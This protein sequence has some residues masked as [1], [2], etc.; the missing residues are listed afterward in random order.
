MNKQ[1]LGWLFF[2]ALIS[3]GI[4][5]SESMLIDVYKCSHEGRVYQ[6]CLEQ[7][8][9]ILLKH[10]VV[11]ESEC[12]PDTMSAQEYNRIKKNLLRK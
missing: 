7:D 12:V 3:Y 8:Y 11:I 2:F 5:H 1:I 4:Y 9:P 10:K 6:V